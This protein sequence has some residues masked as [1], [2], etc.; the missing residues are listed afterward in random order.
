MSP[1]RGGGRALLEITPGPDRSR[2][3]AAMTATGWWQHYGTERVTFGNGEQLHLAPPGGVPDELDVLWWAQGWTGEALLGLGL[4]LDC[5]WRE[6]PRLRARVVHPYLPYSRS[7][8]RS[9]RSGLGARLVLSLVDAVP[10]V[11]EHVGFD[12]HTPE[13]V[14]FTRHP[15]TVLGVEEDV[16]LW[17]EG[18]GFDVVVAPDAGRARTCHDLAERLGIDVEVLLKRRTG[19]DDRSRAVELARPALDGARVLVLDDE[20]TTGETLA[21]AARA[22]ARCGATHVEGLVVR[23]LASAGALDRL[24]A[25]P[26]LAGLVTTDLTAP[27]AA[28]AVEAAG[29]TVIPVPRAVSALR[30]V[31]TQQRSLT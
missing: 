13:V 20:L 23:S 21:G 29:G 26:A 5:L 10:A 19:H 7:T 25:E 8:R 14:G 16:A 12:L 15:M 31:T 11:A 30:P 9:A 6:N 1:D 28:L 24:Q 2:L 4:A 3:G 18:R 27:A 22:A 17:A